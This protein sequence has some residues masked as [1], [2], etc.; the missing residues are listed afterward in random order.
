MFQIQL[1][2]ISGRSFVTSTDD[3]EV[4]IYLFLHNKQ[5]NVEHYWQIIFTL[6]RLSN[7]IVAKKIFLGTVFNISE[8]FFTDSFCSSLFAH[9]VE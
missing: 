5:K 8:V 3:Q 2:A 4:L 7:N 1:I 9:T 6:K